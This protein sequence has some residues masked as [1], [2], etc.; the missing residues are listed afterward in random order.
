MHILFD[1][2]QVEIIGDYDALI[3]RSATTVTAPIIQAGKKLKIIGRAGIAVYM[4]GVNVKPNPSNVMSSNELCAI[5]ACLLCL[6]DVMLTNIGERRVYVCG[7]CCVLQAWVWTTSTW[8][9]Q[10]SRGSSW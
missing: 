3:V 7:A 8:P 5:S 1:A 4:C 10:R 2:A 9:R 6:F